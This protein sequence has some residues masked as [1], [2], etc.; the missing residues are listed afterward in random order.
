MDI[1]LIS[2]NDHLK[3]YLS[4]DIILNKHKAYINNGISF[5]NNNI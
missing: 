2:Y 1:Y 3:Y 4:I 5:I